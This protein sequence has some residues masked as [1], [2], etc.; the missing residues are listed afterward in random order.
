M[1]NL[2]IFPVVAMIACL[3]GYGAGAA[4]PVVQSLET[5]SEIL[6]LIRREKLDV[7]LPGAMRDNDV[8]MWINVIRSGD[9]DPMQL[10]F[11][12]VWGYVIF[13]DPGEGR[14]ERAIFG[15]GGHPDLFDHFGSDEISRAIEGYDYGLVDDSVYDELRQYVAERDPETIAINSSDW[16]AIAD[17]LS[18]SQYLKLENVLGEEYARRFVSA[19]HLITDFRSR[20]TQGE[21]VE[22]AKSLE[23]HRQL[24]IR[25]LSREV[26]TPGV[27]TLEDVG[28]WVVEESERLGVSFG[29]DSYIP[30]PRI[31]YSAVSDSSAPPDVRW[32]IYDPRQ[33]IQ[34]GDFMTYDISVRHLEYFTTDY[35]RNAYVFREG[36]DSI[37]GSIQRAFDRAIR[38]HGIMRPHIRAGRTARQTLDALVA[39]LEAEGYLYTPFIDIGTEDYIIIQNALADTDVPGFSIDL[40]AMGNNGGSLVTVGASVAPF[41]KDRFDLMLQENTFFSFEYMV[42]SHL[43]ERPGLPVS[44]NIEG[45]HLITGRG[46]EYLHPRNERILEIR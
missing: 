22:F 46:V 23:I 26:I 4:D 17:G 35:K 37:P 14:V 44:I 27:T 29:V 43:A 45:N 20:R 9:P 40:H 2:K 30:M 19:E 1:H 32:R 7:V 3:H 12:P 36:E 8:D 34:R 16:L 10:H 41:R 33:V 6:H 42:H 21:I 18:H 25:A 13:S 31:L 24:L 39:A 5:K 15:S 38:A 11:G 28:R